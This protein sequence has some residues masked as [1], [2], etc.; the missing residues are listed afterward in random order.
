MEN[1]RML[2][3]WQN[4]SGTLMAF[5]MSLT[6]NA[7]DAK[8]LYQETA[9]SAFKNSRKLDEDSNIG[10]WLTTIMKNK[11]INKYRRKK[12]TPVFYD[13]TPNN[14]LINSGE[15]TIENMGQSNL[16][17]E[18][19][20]SR[21]AELPDELRIPF[22]MHFQGYKY[23]EIADEFNVPLGTMKSRIFHARKK[24]RETVTQV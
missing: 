13:E 6:K 3:E 16:I 12:R 11:F 21:I 4:L 20:K 10:G 9:Y 22:I 17:M 24:L 2:N 1:A 23:R 15:E 7:N 14:Y 8:D 5:A 18:E 19:L